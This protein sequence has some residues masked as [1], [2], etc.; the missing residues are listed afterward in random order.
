MRAS[1]GLIKFLA[2]LK[3]AVIL[4]VVLIAALIVATTM[5]SVYSTETARSLIYN[6]PWFSLLF[7]FLALNVLASAFVRFPWKKH[8]TGFVLAHLGILSIL[9]GAWATRSFGVDARISLA[10]GVPS[11]EILE[12]HPTFYFQEGEASYQAKPLSFPWLKPSPD[13]PYVF[14]PQE[15]VTVALDRFYPNAGRVMRGIPVGTGEGA[16][17][18]ALHLKLEGSMGTQDF[19]LFLGHPEMDRLLLGPAAVV[20]QRASHWNPANLEGLGPNIL[21]LLL[22]D[23]GKLSFRIRHKGD[24]GEVKGL[25]PGQKQDTGWANMTFS[26]LDFFPQALPETVYEPAPLARQGTPQPALHYR[27]GSSA[28]L[29]EGWL[30]YDGSST[31]HLGGHFYSLAY[32]EKELKLPFALKLEKFHIGM[33]PGTTQPASFESQVRVEPENGGAGESVTIQMNHPLD[34][35]G[36]VFYQ[37]SYQAMENGGYLSVLSVARDPGVWLKYL[38]SVILVAGIAFMFWFKKPILRDVSQA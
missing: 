9:A 3:L 23:A 8:Q 19:W 27:L 11:S 38:G 36:Y 13:H 17:L 33:N 18:P 12:N 31:I 22:D 5:E 20:L 32:G 29:K 37:A 16:G 15:G 24:W 1:N 4:I 7:V 10:E 25:N 26:L 14:S 21:A 28:G 34:Y 35:G 2:S 6:S 30:G